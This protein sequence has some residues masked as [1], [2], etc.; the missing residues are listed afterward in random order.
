MQGKN[1]Y[2]VVFFSN[3]HVLNIHLS[4]HIAHQI[5]IQE[6]YACSY[7]HPMTD[8]NFSSQLHTIAPPSAPKSVGNNGLRH[9]WPDQKPVQRSCRRQALRQQITAH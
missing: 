6:K 4:R 5:W 7:C 2:S 9:S 1:N 8:N 3:Y